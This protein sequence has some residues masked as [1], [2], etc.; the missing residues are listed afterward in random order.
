M[1]TLGCRRRQYIDIGSDD[2]LQNAFIFYQEPY[3]EFIKSFTIL[4]SMENTMHFI[5]EKIERRIP[6]NHTGLCGKEEDYTK[7][8]NLDWNIWAIKQLQY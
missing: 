7:K 3:Y 8:T 5:Y 4:Y 6:E 1:T 2:L